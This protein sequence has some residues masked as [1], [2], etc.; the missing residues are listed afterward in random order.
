MTESAA[1][2]PDLLHRSAAEGARLVALRFL[3]EAEAAAARLGDAA[4][5]EALH[6]FRV[7]LRRLRSTLR[8]FRDVLRRAIPKK[9]RRA[10]RALA[11]RTN[12][13]R[14]AEVQLAWLRERRDE[15]GAGTRTGWQALVDR[16]DAR[17][18]A[19]YDGAV[20]D[21]SGGFPAAARRIRKALTHY[22]TR[23]P[24]PDAPAP[25]RFGGAAA[26]ALTVATDTFVRALA[27]VSSADAAAEAHAARIAAKRVRY[28]LEPLAAHVPGA[29]SLLR[30]F[31]SLQD[32]LGEL[33]D[34]HVL[35]AEVVAA[36]AAEGAARAE[37]RHRAGV[38]DGAAA[39]RR[40]GRRGPDPRRGLLAVARL[41]VARRRAL[42]TRLDEEWLADR[43]AGIAAELAAAA[44]DLEAGS[45]PPRPS[46]RHKRDPGWLIRARARG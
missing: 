46:R 8:A 12:A 25:P 21:V 22:R 41:L 27:A 2:P 10:L 38:R 13:G 3:D 17:R 28:A 34:C 23:V 26:A 37:R 16:L 45:P 30:R 36:V 11:R 1:L 20:A 14:D 44:A 32:L 18:A 19:E 43:G 31:K 4:D 6:D 24:A 29:P 9:Q 33:N 42:F 40:A 15:L 35:E 39:A 7:A 5:G